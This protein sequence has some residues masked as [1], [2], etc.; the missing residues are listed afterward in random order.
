MKKFI[1]AM[2]VLGILEISLVLYLTW[3]R[4]IFWN[5]ISEKDLAGSIKYIIIFTIVA[6]ALCVVTALATYMSTRAA[7]IWREALNKKA[8]KMHTKEIVLANCV[9]VKSFPGYYINNSGELYSD[10][11][12]K[13]KQMKPTKN[14]VGYMQVQLCKN[15]KHINKLIHRLVAEAY[16]HNNNESFVMINHINGIKH[17]NRVENLEWCDS[18]RNNQHAY[19]TGLNSCKGTKNSQCKLSSEDVRKIRELYPDMRIID[20]S[21]LYNVC[22]SSIS[23]IVHNRTWRHLL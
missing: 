23:Q 22:E 14:S 8:Y 3:W 6:L 21:K 11:R 1:V 7:I 5:Y 20:I 10:Y 16:I 18:T 2:G 17:D 9:P 19:Q 15:K 4:K 12:F 13:F